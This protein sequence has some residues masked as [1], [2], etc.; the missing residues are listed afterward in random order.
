MAIG[1]TWARVGKYKINSN[2]EYIVSEITESQMTVEGS[3]WHLENRENFPGK[4]SFQET[5]VPNGSLYSRSDRGQED[6][7]TRPGQ[8]YG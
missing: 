3:G 8:L 4:R 5:L 7:H 2:S 1:K 6:L